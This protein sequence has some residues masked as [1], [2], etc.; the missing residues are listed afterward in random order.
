M[1]NPIRL[2]ERQAEAWNFLNDDITREI[3]Y[4]WWAGWWKTKLGSIWLGSMI[5]ALPGST[6]CIGRSELKKIKL[7]T[8]VTF[9]QVLTELGFSD[10]SYRYD[11]QKGVLTFKNGCKVVLMDLNYNPSDPEFDRLGS[12]E[13]TWA[14]IDESQEIDDKARQILSSRLRNLLGQN[15]FT[16][17]D[18]SAAEKRIVDN[19]KGVLYY[20]EVLKEYWVVMWQQKVPKLFMSCNPGRNF[21]YT[22]FYKPRKNNTLEEHR[23]F[24]QSLPTDNPFLPQSY[25]E[26]LKNL[27]KVSRERLLYGNFDYSDD[28]WLLFTIDELSEMFVD[29]EP[30]R[31]RY[32]ITVDAARQ[33]KDSTVIW[34]WKW[35]HLFRIVKIDKWS[36][37]VQKEKIQELIEQYDVSVEN[38]IIDEVWVGGWLV[39][40]LWCRWFIANAA[41]LQPYS[42][43]LLPYMKRNYQNLKVQAFFYLQ[44]YVRDWKVSIK[45]G[46]QLKEEIIEELLF[47][48]QIDL[49]NDSKIKLESKKEL[50]ERLWKS[51]DLA[52][53]ISFRMYW[54]IKEH[55]EGEIAPEDK[56]EVDEKEDLLSFLMAEEDTESVWPDLDVYD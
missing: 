37:T 46:W 55:H 18:K 13:F 20:N 28:P 16:T 39:D 22:D 10:K 33:G 34:V 4:G 43:R 19:G 21:I 27:D 24:V 7:S 1:T 44:K 48:R 26:N 35:L 17:T 56:T 5:A 14:F 41:P 9:R 53:M 36:L 29:R 54:L 25:I 32:Y 8:L 45:A 51:P 47:V 6:W 50:K 23:Q 40:M 52:D 38:V 49:D 31:A 2:F 3:V 12:M 30:K 11:D 42:A 15:L